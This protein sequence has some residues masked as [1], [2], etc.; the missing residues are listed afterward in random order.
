MAE[1]KWQE[2]NSISAR[3]SFLKG[4]DQE[5]EMKPFHKY[6]YFNSAIDLPG[7]ICQCHTSLLNHKM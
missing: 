5:R 3:V 6:Y 7:D 4:L 2:I 1:R